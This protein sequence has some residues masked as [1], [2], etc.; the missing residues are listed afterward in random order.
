MTIPHGVNRKICL[1]LYGH[2][3]GAIYC[4]HPLTQILTYSIFHGKLHW[5]EKN[6]RKL[7][8]ALNIVP[9]SRV[10][11]PLPL[12]LGPPVRFS[13]SYASSIIDF[14]VCSPPFV[15]QK[16]SINLP[17]SFAAAQKLGLVEAELCKGNPE[18]RIRKATAN[19]PLDLYIRKL[20]ASDF[21]RGK[22]G[23]NCHKQFHEE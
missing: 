11:Y 5:K 6:Q 7:V 21:D 10:Q 13:F 4:V 8:F 15:L 22:A 20:W 23:P 18:L 1:T 12:G 9:Q 14:Q 3:E 16:P 2:E 17:W 19:G